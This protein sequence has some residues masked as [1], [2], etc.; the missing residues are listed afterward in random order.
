MKLTIERAALLKTLAHVQSAVERRNTIPILSNVL[1]DVSEG[2]LALTATDM[3]LT[4]VDAVPVEM[5]EPG[6]TTAPV[7][8]LYDIVRKLPEGA[9]VEISTGGDGSQITIESGR[10]VF[11]L[12][13]LPKEDFPSAGAADLPHAFTLQPGELRNLI[14][15]T[16][17]AI[18]TEETRYYL[19]GIYLHAAKT[20]DLDVLRAVATDG[21]RLARFEMP[22]PDGA[23]DMPGVIVP[24]KTVGELRK[25][26]DETDQPVD[27]ALSDTKIRFSFDATVLSS[28]LI[29]GTFPDYQRVIPVGND[30]IVK[31]NCRD[32]ADAVDR[33][34]TISSE[35][36]RAVKLVIEDGSIRLSATSPENGTATEDVPISYAGPQIEIGFNSSYLLDIARQIEGESAEISLADSA[37]PTV[38]R[39]L[40][41]S[42]AL[43][44]LMPMR[45]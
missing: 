37:S 23:S 32:F 35:K 44:V 43:Y 10:S 28:K 11:T 39:D 21:H 24:R 17:F 30:K 16:R 45:V 18:S 41:D 12:A 29:D 19:N 1:I 25:L 13:T 33:V 38:V 3:D 34:S 40:S 15:R 20:D 7:H 27:V 6:A 14:D 4:I 22:L 26:V 2:N 8:T 36:S 42:S 31:V 9:Q 5:A